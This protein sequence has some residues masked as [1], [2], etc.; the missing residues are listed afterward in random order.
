MRSTYLI[1]SLCGSAIAQNFDIQAV[2]ELELPEVLGPDA[3]NPSFI[4]AAYDSDKAA[5]LAAA[6]VLQD[7]LSL[8]TV[9]EEVVFDR[10]DSLTKRDDCSS[11]TP[12]YDTCPHL[13]RLF[14]N[15]IIGLV[16]SRE[17]AR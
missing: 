11:E 13:P 8:E 15:L 17:M 5:R 2:D 16:Q 7:G 4:P 1:A 6:E 9:I 14:I 3:A 12:G 10:R